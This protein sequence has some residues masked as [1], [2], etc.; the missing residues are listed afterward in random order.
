MLNKKRVA[1]LA[2]D[3]FEESELISPMKALKDAGV[4]AVLVSPKSGEIMSWKDGNWGEKFN[5]DL[6]LENANP[7]NFDALVLPGGVI[8]PD[9]LRQNKRA[10]EFIRG[11]FS[12]ESLKPVAAICHGPLSLIEANM[13]KNRKMTSFNSIK[14][15]LKNAG[16]SWVDEP[17]VCDKGLVTSRTPDDL[18][19]FNNKLIEELKE[20]KHNLNK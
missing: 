15:D 16:A 18:D 11:F 5:V 2:T 10:I 14:T 12:K 8:N 1:I 3:G 17:V 19:D 4:E 9:M 20:G 6:K 13:V 7:D